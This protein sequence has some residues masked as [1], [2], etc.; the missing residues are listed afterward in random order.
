MNFRVEE[1]LERGAQKFEENL[2]KREGNVRTIVEGF[3]GYR[4]EF[5][6]GRNQLH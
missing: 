4:R 3:C 2:L 1:R 6:V 5:F